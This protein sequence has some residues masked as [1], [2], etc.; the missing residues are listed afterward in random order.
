[1]AQSPRE[2]RP[3]GPRKR[4]LSSRMGLEKSGAPRRSAPPQRQTPPP[5]KRRE[6]LTQQ[7]NPQKPG[8][9]SAAPRRQR[10]V[11]QAELTRKR[12][13]RRMIGVLAIL[14]VLAV[15]AFVSVNLL[16]KVTLFRVESFDRSPADTGIYTT[17][18]IINAL[19]I[20]KNSNL[21]GFSTSEKTQQLTQQ[22]PYLERVEVAVQLPATVVIR[23]E[24][25]VERFTCMYSGGWVVLSDSLKIL[26]T[27][28][29]RPREL[30]QL[31]AVLPENFSPTIGAVITPQSYN[32]LL[33]A[34]QATAETAG[35]QSSA[36]EVLAELR[37]E[38]TKYGLMDGTTAMDISDLSS[39][40]FCYQDRVQVLLGSDSNLSYKLQMAAAALLDPDKGLAESDAGTLDISSQQS[41]GEIRAYFAP[42]EPDPTPTPEPAPEENTE[43]AETTPAE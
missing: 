15:G 42:N 36:S 2:K 21:F 34:E 30:I 37:S 5:Q 18:E 43:E 19:G 25:A 28:L 10:R 13:R 29:D 24:P 8:Y 32:S 27:E 1:M 33:G 39:L 22:F 3:G 40:S 14:A 35:L 26:R 4:S 11:T 31:T 38:L 7:I 12:N 6:R 41:S 23:V 20:E 17:D 16:F 9:D